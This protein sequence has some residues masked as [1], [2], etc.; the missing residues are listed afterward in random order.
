MMLLN[1]SMKFNKK[2]TRI[3][4][5]NYLKDNYFSGGRSTQMY[6]MLF[7]RRRMLPQ[8]ALNLSLTRSVAF[9]SSTFMWLS[10]R[11]MVPRYSTPFFRT[12]ET[13]LFICLIK[14]FKGFLLGSNEITPVIVLLTHATVYKSYE[15]QIKRTQPQQGQTV[16]KGNNKIK[17]G[18]I[19]PKMP[20]NISST[21]F[22]SSFS[23]ASVLKTSYQKA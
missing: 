8:F 21:S 2:Q 1:L 14:A 18:Q 11:T 20:L 9:S 22:W 19:Q 15:Q 16:Q 12:M 5:T 7:P 6:S 17:M 23:Y 10:Q 13:K 3:N 4:K